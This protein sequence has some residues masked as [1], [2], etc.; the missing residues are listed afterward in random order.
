MKSTTT[1]STTEVQISD[2]QAEHEEYLPALMM[3]DD[4]DTFYSTNEFTTEYSSAQMD[5]YTVSGDYA[6]VN[7]VSRELYLVG[8][9]NMEPDVNKRTD[10][11]LLQVDSNTKIEIETNVKKSVKEKMRNIENRL[12][13]ARL[14]A[15]IVDLYATDLQID[16][17]SAIV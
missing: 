9:T 13:P 14:Q 1:T 7:D 15:G 3:F 8:Q 11:I 17:C 6:W 16:G 2:E 5:T 12:V 10:D 4:N